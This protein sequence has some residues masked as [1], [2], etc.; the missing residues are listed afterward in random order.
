[1]NEK[2]NLLHKLDKLEDSPRP[3]QKVEDQTKLELLLFLKKQ[4]ELA[5]SQNDLKSL[6]VKKLKSYLEDSKNDSIQPVIL[7]K[8]LEILV[9]SENEKTGSILNL[10]KKPDTII[11]NISSI[12]NKSDD[13]KQIE[14]NLSKEE[15][16]SAVKLLDTLETLIKSSPIKENKV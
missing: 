10:L 2:E 9:K 6:T 15:Y 14:K 12:Q 7:I 11:N 8:L 1:M 16:Q 3:S 5:G 13:L 4:I